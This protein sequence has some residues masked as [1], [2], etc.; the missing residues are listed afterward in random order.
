MSYASDGPKLPASKDHTLVFSML[1]MTLPLYI[2]F[3]KCLSTFFIFLF[4]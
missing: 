2:S 4:F 1:S 3:L